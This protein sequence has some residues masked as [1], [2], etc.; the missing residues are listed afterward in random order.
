MDKLHKRSVYPLPQYLFEE[1]ENLD[2]LIC[3]LMDA[4]ER[5][6][7]KLHTGRIPWYPTYKECCQTLEYWL[8]RKSHYKKENRNVR[9]LI[10]L[11]NK[12]NILYNA[13][14]S[15]A[16]IDNKIIILHKERKKCKLLAESLSYE[17][18]TQLA[19][20]KEEAGEMKAATFL[21]IANNIEA[22]RRMY[23]NIR[24]MEGKVKGSSTSKLTA[25]SEEGH[26]IKLTDK[27]EI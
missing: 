10:V 15:L 3:K 5:Q 8:N 23:L 26:Q 18:R 4:A 14:L 6:C 20:A 13:D 19:L 21:R 12:L 22:Q 2:V 1:Y 9:Q 17:Y 25:T 27:L 16:D 7:R 24:Y 11:Q